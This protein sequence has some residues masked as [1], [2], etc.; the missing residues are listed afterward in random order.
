MLSIGGRVRPVCST[1]ARCSAHRILRLPWSFLRERR[2]KLLNRTI[3]T[4]LSVRPDSSI[5]RST[6]FPSSRAQHHGPRRAA[7]L[8]SL[9]AGRRQ[10]DAATTATCLFA[11]TDRSGCIGDPSSHR[12]LGSTANWPLRPRDDLGPLSPGHFR[13]F[14][15]PRGHFSRESVHFFEDGTDI[16]TSRDHPNKNGQILTKTHT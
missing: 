3:A 13:F 14:P 6:V 4:R 1:T 8:G 10:N 7:L 16:G 2:S 15:A 9:P 12:P 5:T 11:L